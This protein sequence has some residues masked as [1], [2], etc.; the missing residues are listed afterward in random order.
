MGACANCEKC[1]RSAGA[2]RMAALGRG[3]A[4]MA[5]LGTTL[6]ASNWRRKCGVCQHPQSEHHAIGVQGNY[7][8]PQQVIVQPQQVYQPQPV[9]QQPIAPPQPAGPPPGWYDDPEDAA[10]KR[11]WDGTQ[12]TEHRQQ[13]NP[14]DA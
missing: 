10:K 11:W 3:S 5:T 8:Q 2:K 9:Y 12:W 13:P 1:G 14:P 7:Q 4:H 6:I